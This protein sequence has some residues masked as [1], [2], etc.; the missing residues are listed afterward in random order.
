MLE[1]E[2]CRAVEH[3]TINRGERTLQ[4]HEE[5]VPNLA[6]ATDSAINQ[7]IRF[8]GNKTNTLQE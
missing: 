8:L 5:Y 3:L 1:Y 2:I 4:L 6:I 7:W